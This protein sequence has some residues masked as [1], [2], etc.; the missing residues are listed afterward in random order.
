MKIFKKKSKASQPKPFTSKT[1]SGN[2]KTG[3]DTVIKFYEL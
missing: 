3:L 1:L 2:K